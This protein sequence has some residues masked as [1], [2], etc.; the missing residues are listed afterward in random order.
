MQYELRGY[1]ERIVQKMVL[2]R[3]QEGNELLSICQGAGKSIIIAELARRLDEPILILV[4]SKELLEQNLEKLK[5]VI[6]DDIGVYSASMN[7]KEVKH[8]TIGTIQSVHKD[9]GLFRS[10]DLVIL[11]ECDL[12]NVEESNMYS[13]LF[14]GAGIKKVYGLTGSPYRMSSFYRNP[15]GWSGY[16]GKFWQKKNLEVVT[17]IKM[18][19]RFKPKNGVFF[20]TRMLYVLN[21]KELQEEG[22]LTKLTY[23]DVSVIDHDQ[24]PTNKS[25]SDF[26]LEAFDELCNDY[27]LYASF[28][29][30]LNHK[31][32][33]VFCSSIEQ[34][35]KLSSL[36]EGSAVVTSQTKKKERASIINSFKSGD[37]RVL[38]GVLIFAVGFDVPELDCIVSLRPTKSLRLW[39]QLLGRGA[40]IAPGKRTCTVYDFVGN[41]K[42][43]GKLESIAVTKIDGKWDVVSNT[44]R[45]GFHQKEL[46]SH[47]LRPKRLLGDEL[48]RR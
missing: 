8:I 33:L 24:I 47:V 17:C 29:G 9:P 22:Y 45:T 1:Q 14:K 7:T 38:F 41:I 11:D 34:A 23:Q 13:K 10:I 16:T 19:N 32:V 26:D 46:Y 42:T 20:W 25:K 4:P 40:R 2:A 35:T 12:F 6:G 21:T 37:I 30:G 3:E 48:T 39:S 5:A 27:T 15:N 44:Y 28:I 36:V 43:M 18:I 31:R